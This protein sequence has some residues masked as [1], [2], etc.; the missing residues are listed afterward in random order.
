[1]EPSQNILV[2]KLGAFGDFVQALGPMAAIRRHHPDAQITLLT[3][4][5]F[6]TLARDSGYFDRIWL[7]PKPRWT[8]IKK[9]AGLARQLRQGQFTRVYD[10]QNN[11]RTAFYLWL[12][13]LKKGNRPEWVGAA[14]GASHRNT[15]PS[16]TAGHALDGHI[17]TL[18]LAGITDVALDDL[19][20]VR[21]DTA[22]FG[23]PH[24]YILLVPGSTPNHLGKRWPAQ[25]Y[26]A[27]ARHL[28]GWG[29]TPVV[30]GTVDEEPLAKKIKTLCPDAI[31]LCAQTSLMDLVAL[32]RNAAGAIGND[33]GP[34]H[35]IAPTRCPTIVLFSKHSD[36]ARHA[37]QGVRVR[38]I[39]V[40]DLETLG[41]DDLL[42][43]ISVRDFRHKGATS[44]A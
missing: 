18:A 5:P 15:S 2:I 27:L 20:W 3:T 26:G 43:Q 9:I 36:P 41:I 23:L 33:T 28:Y 1:M 7:D 35:L 38:T 24:P 11:D 44:A 37:P 13:G 10:L 22:H 42:Q 21:T 40:D 25:S 8:G 17:Q 34:M 14:Y 16:R 6:M 31:N 29:F 32:A 30:I 12:F 4:A 19:S 39:Q